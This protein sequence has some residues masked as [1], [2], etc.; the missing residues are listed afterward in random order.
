MYSV[1][2]VVEKGFMILSK[3]RM[4]QGCVAMIVAACGVVGIIHLCLQ[5]RDLAKKFLELAARDCNVLRVLAADDST[6][7]ELDM[8]NTIRSFAAVRL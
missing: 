1:C 3:P 7:D 4:S 6:A 8:V 5:P 2:S